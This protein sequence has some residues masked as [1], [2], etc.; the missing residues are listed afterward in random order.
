MG[1]V[2]VPR[3]PVP[4]ALQYFTKKGAVPDSWGAFRR[5]GA[6][7]QHRTPGFGQSG[8]PAAAQTQIGKVAIGLGEADAHGYI[9]Q[10]GR[11]PQLGLLV[12]VA[13]RQAQQL[14][15]RGG[16]RRAGPVFP[17]PS[18]EKVQRSALRAL[19]VVRV[20]WVPGTNR[21][22]SAA[23]SAPS[24]MNTLKRSCT[25]GPTA[26]CGVLALKV[27]RPWA[28][29]K[30]AACSLRERSAKRSG[31]S[32]CG[33]T[34]PTLLWGAAAHQKGADLLPGFV[35]AAVV[36]PQ[37]L[38]AR[39]V[40]N[41]FA[42]P[43]TSNVRRTGAG[44]RTAGAAVLAMRPVPPPG[45][46]MSTPAPVPLSWAVAGAVAGA[47]FRGWGMVA[48]PHWPGLRGRGHH[49]CLRCRF[50]LG[51]CLG[52]GRSLVVFRREP[53]VVIH[54][55]RRGFGPVPGAL[56]AVRWPLPSPWG[57]GAGLR[58]GFLCAAAGRAGAG[59]ACAT[60]GAGRRWGQCCGC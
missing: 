1:R 54:R 39:V 30:W 31:C 52:R 16:S 28:W 18:I 19:T 60:T 48:L 29:S 14:P 45:G 55:F 8:R 59:D 10:I 43:F 12:V 23:S 22:G 6:R 15:G 41:F 56:A 57:R 17:A 35:T 46:L 36:L 33:V 34:W 13:A 11:Q 27:T 40:V 2:Q 25:P 21:A 44:R 49:L 53:M 20:T 24:W 26:A 47:G 42:W 9:A 38:G 50:C 51:G 3:L 5:N 37:Q 7:K 4:D 58:R 32:P